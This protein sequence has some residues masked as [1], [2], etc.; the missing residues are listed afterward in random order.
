MFPHFV[1]SRAE[2]QLRDSHA[3]IQ[4][5]KSGSDPSVPVC[6]GKIIDIKS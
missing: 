1:F 6:V 4:G 5:S 3:Y 2:E